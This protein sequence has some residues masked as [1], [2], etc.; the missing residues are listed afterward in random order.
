MIISNIC[1]YISTF[2]HG[3]SPEPQSHIVISLIQYFQFIDPSVDSNF[4]SLK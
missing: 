2:S 3:L 4:T 1:L